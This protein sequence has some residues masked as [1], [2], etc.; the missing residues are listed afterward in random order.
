MTPPFTAHTQYSLY[1]FGLQS[2]AWNKMEMEPL[3]ISAE[4]NCIIKGTIVQST[5]RYDN[6][7]PRLFLERAS[8]TY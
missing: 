2:F 3:F 8:H 1:L 6:T 4:M 7:L 5:G